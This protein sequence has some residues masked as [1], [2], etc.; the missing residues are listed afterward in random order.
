M[1]EFPLRITRH[2]AILEVVLDVPKANAARALFSSLNSARA[3]LRINP[4]TAVSCLSPPRP[5]RK[6]CA[7][8]AGSSIRRSSRR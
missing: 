6:S 4:S 1:A 7:A 5:A 3:A 2:G 8:R